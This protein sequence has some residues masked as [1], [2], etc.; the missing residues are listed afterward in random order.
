MQSVVTDAPEEGIESTL[1]G[2]LDLELPD[3]STEATRSPYRRQTSLL[4]Q[5]SLVLYAL[6]ICAALSAGVALAL[7]A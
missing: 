7:M 4:S 5:D 3:A 1:A 6:A 2:F